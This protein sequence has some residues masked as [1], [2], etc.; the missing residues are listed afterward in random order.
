MQAR[1]GKFIHLGARVDAAVVRH[2]DEGGGGEV[3]DEFPALPDKSVGMAGGTDGDG[4]AGRVGTDQPRPGDRD[5]IGAVPCPAGNHDGG[6]GGEKRAALP[7]N[8]RHKQVSFLGCVYTKPMIPHE[9]LFVKPTLCQ[10][11]VCR[12]FI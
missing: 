8:F 4:H 9:Y 7:M 5:D 6:R 12:V 11:G 3:D 1:G 2:A 10:I